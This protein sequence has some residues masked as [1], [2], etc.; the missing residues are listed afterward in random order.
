MGMPA[1]EFNHKYSYSDYLTWTD[2]KRWEIIDGIVYNMTPAPSSVHQRILGKLFLI[3]E[4]F[5]E[6]DKCEVFMAPL[7]V[8]LSKDKVNDTDIETVVQPDILVVCDKNK[9]DDRG[10]NGAP[11]FI[12]E[13][14]SPSTVYKDTV[15]KLNLYEKYGI[16]E[17][18]IVY[19][20]EQIITVYTLNGEKYEKPKVY[21]YEDKVKSI[22][23]NNLEFESNTVFKR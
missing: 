10:C 23:F 2:N 15:V 20:E 16:K 5:F 3:M 6:N 11:D 14:V 4:H 22:F 18:W 17:Y 1:K 8:R 9:V 21:K 13:I 19:P 7:D 12:I